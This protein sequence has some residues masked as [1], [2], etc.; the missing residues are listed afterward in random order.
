MIQVVLCLG[1]NTND[2]K[3]LTALL[4]AVFLAIPYWKNRFFRSS[5]AKGA[6]KN[7]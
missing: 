2:L 6:G 4:V 5:A 1:L 7:A 3:L